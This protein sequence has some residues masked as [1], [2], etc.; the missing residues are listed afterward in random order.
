MS[1]EGDKA[2][3]RDPGVL[4]TLDP[5]V[6]NNQRP[7]SR[8]RTRRWGGGKKK[9]IKTNENNKKIKSSRSKSVLTQRVKTKRLKVE[10]LLG[11]GGDTRVVSLSLGPASSGAL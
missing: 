4:N 2:W 10:I 3:S 11:G 1:V 8:R 7:V 9:K 6:S 5:A